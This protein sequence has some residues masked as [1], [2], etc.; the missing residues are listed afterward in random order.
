MAG[1]ARV[2]ELAKELG[3][4]S[5]EVLARLSEQGEF[6]KSASSTVEAPVARRLRESFGGAKPA[7]EKVKAARQR[8]AGQGSRRGRDEGRARK[9]PGAQAR[10]RPRRPRH[11]QTGGRASRGGSSAPPPAAPAAGPARLPR[12]AQRPGPT[13]GP[14]ARC[15]QAGRAHPARRQQ[16]VLL[17]AAG[18]PA[19]SA[20][21]RSPARS[22]RPAA[23]CAAT[24]HV[25]GQHAAASRRCR[26]RCVPAAVPVAPRPG[27]G[28]RGPGAG[29]GG[30]P[31]GAGGGGG[32]NYRGGG[33]GG[34]AGGGGWRCPGG[35]R[36]SRPSRWRRRWRRTARSA[37]RSRRRVRS[38]RRRA[39]A[40]PQVEAAEA[41]GIR[42]DAGAGRRW[43]AV[44]ARQ[45]RDHPAGPRR[46]AV[47]LR[48]EDRRQPGLAGA[49]AVQ[50]RRDGDRHPV[51]RRRDPRAARQRDEL[52]RPGRVSPRTRTASCWSPS[53]SPTA[54]TRAARTTSRPVRR[55]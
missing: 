15:A 40:W 1:K 13:S 12:P 30:R 28:G 29:T 18:R 48:R 8:L 17:G 31:G 5:K 39:E 49:G 3:V 38:S 41:P 20:S 14:R 19:H 50:P 46:V 32:G 11:P 27:P 53:T 9:A 34:G 36:L 23:G 52:R 51:R 24:R 6:V 44:A 2:H 25:A 42:L 26:A 43:R 22:R 55:W 45:R 7:A 10:R 37:R 16:P 21:A 54:R 33:G 35:C 4:T 47:R